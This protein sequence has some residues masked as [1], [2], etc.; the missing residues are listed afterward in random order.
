[1][2]VGEALA[3]G[4]FA[5]G[6]AET[7]M[8]NKAQ[9]QQIY[10]EAYR[11]TYNNAINEYR[12][13]KQNEATA[14]AFSAKIDFVKNQI[15]NNYLAAEASWVSEQ[16]RLNEI[17]D[18][19]AYKSESMRKMLIE[20]MGTN[21]AR[22]VYGTSARRGALVS[23]LGAYGRSRAQLVDSLMS[24]TAATQLRMQRTEQ[25][26]KAQNKLAISQTSILPTA[27]TF[28]AAP[29][30]GISV[31]GFGQ[32]ALQI[33]GIAMGAFTAGYSATPTGSSFLGIEKKG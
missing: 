32:Q 5:F 21:A 12:T 2:L 26:F 4:Q 1:M 29:L 31:P 23:T 25:Q 3:L 13:Q 10:N 6:I 15:E 33:G 24:E 9:E 18:T 8:G 19:A 11:T 20:T 16:I 17:Y 14:N 22:E 27:A 7:F 28:A 30:P